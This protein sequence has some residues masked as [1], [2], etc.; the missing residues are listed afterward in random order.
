MKIQ[1]NYF[2]FLW[3]HIS[4]ISSCFWNKKVKKLIDAEELMIKMTIERAQISHNQNILELGCG[5]GSMSLWIA[6]NYP[7]SQITA[8]SNSSVQKDYIDSFNYPNLTVITS[9]MNDFSTNHKFDRIISIEMFEHM[10]N[11][12]K[13]LKNISTWLSDDGFLFVH[14]FTHKNLSYLLNGKEKI[15]WMSENFSK[16][17]M[18]PSQYLLPICNDH[19]ITKKMWHVNGKHYAKKHYALGLIIL[20]K[21]KKL[22]ILYLKNTILKKKSSTLFCRWRIFFIACEELF[23]FGKGEE[24]FVTHYLLE[25]R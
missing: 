12:N 9:D 24:W 11:W 10:R 13:L 2:K 15:N 4:N 16:E 17:G 1:L 6:K 25:K 23:G 18:F 8:V 19:L 20:I 3:D 22:F 7:S 21:I 5:W 14:I